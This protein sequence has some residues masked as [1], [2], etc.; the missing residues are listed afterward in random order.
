M[1]VTMDRQGRFEIPTEL[2]E[3]L[4]LEAG[5]PLEVSEEEGRLVL[6]PAPPALQLV[7]KDGVLTAVSD[8]DLPVL[9]AVRV[10][11][12]LEDTRSRRVIE[13]DHSRRR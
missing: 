9:T 8:R 10:R 12:T 3:Q 11:E 1:K 7:E 13:L 4:G 6:V 5:C 2:R